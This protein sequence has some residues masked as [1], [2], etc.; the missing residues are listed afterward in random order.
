MV[1]NS[2]KQLEVGGL[3]ALRQQASNLAMQDVMPRIS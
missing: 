3:D 2:W 1:V